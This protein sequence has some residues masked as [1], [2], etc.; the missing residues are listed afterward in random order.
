MVGPVG[1]IVAPQLSYTT[2]GAGV[3]PVGRTGHRRTAVSRHGEVQALDGVGVHP[4]V[5]V[6]FAVGVVPGVGDRAFTIT[7][8][9]PTG[10]GRV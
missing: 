7:E 8:V 10:P 1:V 9:P 4:I 6:A 2:G 3:R 5:V